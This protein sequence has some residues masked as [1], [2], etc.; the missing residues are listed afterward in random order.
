MPERWSAVVGG[1][2]SDYGDI[3]A[4][5]ADADAQ[6]LRRHG[7][8]LGLGSPDAP[9]APGTALGATEA[10][11]GDT[12]VIPPKPRRLDRFSGVAEPVHDPEPVEVQQFDSRTLRDILARLL[13]A[14]DAQ[15]GDE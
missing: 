1:S 7:H 4:A 14:A 6:W 3:D 9:Q 10:S 8:K 13:A 15:R 12:V 5:Q 2:G 11:E